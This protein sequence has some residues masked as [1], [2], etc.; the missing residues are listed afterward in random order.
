MK[1]YVSILAVLPVLPIALVSP[2][3]E[4]FVYAALASLI[5]A[6]L[7]GIA[8]FIKRKV[9]QKPK[10]DALEV[11]ERALRLLKELSTQNLSIEEFHARK[12]QILNP[13][14]SLGRQ[15]QRAWA[16]L[17]QVVSSEISATGDMLESF[18]WQFRVDIRLRKRLDQEEAVM[19]AALDALLNA[20]YARKGFSEAM[21][22]IESQ[23]AWRKYWPD[24]NVV[25]AKY[26][27]KGVGAMFYHAEFAAVMSDRAAMLR[28][29]L[30][31]VEENTV[32]PLPLDAPQLTP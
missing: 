11:S 29:R 23:L 24:Y 14:K 4:K 30:R 12:E 17:A 10:L 21:D 25:T 22:I 9:E 32:L 27:D 31:E 7:G 16:Q 26:E 3:Q 18:R 15:D 13:R 5:T 6:I 28:S 1:D 2:E 8:Y 19:F 20:L